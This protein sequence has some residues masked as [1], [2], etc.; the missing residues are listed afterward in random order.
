MMIVVVAIFAVCWLP[1]HTYFIVSNIHPAI[2]H[3]KYI[4]VSFFKLNNS[5]EIRFPLV[6]R[7]SVESYYNI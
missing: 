2:N 5:G 3:S 6:Y 7:I 1:Y 4:Q